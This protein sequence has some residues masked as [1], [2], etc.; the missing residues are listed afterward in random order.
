MHFRTKQDNPPEDGCSG[1]VQQRRLGLRRP[2]EPENRNKR[3]SAPCVTFC[4]CEMSDDHYPD[5]ERKYIYFH[6]NCGCENRHTVFMHI[7]VFH[8]GSE[9]PGL[10]SRYETP[11]RSI[12]GQSLSKSDMLPTRSTRNTATNPF[13]ISSPGETTVHQI[14][15]NSRGDKCCRW[16][17]RQDLYPLKLQIKY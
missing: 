6:G 11:V 8:F 4:K 1:C 12:P 7:F 5:A 9:D 10:V 17:R 13:F 16:K 15:L 14:H 3:D 2:R